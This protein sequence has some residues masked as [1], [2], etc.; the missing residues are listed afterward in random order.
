MTET[1][2][3]DYIV[4][5]H[6]DLTAEKARDLSSKIYDLLDYECM[7]DQIDHHVHEL[8]TPD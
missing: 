1:E 6:E 3:F 4:Y 7:Y 2:V 8:T 5:C